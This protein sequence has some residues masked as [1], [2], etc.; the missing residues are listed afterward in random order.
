MTSFMKCCVKRPADCPNFIVYDGKVYGWQQV[1]IPTKGVFVFC[2]NHDEAATHAKEI[3]D[4]YY[5][6]LDQR[7]ARLDAFLGQ[8]GIR[9]P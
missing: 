4:D 9:V 6:R 1:E 2:P 8:H 7:N 3:A 5:H